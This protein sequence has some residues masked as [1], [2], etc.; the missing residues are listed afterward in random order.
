[1]TVQK[2]FHWS[3]ALIIFEGVPNKTS[4]GLEYKIEQKDLVY[5]E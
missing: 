4:N 5:G 3:D 1:M 2:L